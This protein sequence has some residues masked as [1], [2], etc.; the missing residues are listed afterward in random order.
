MRYKTFV[1]SLLILSFTCRPLP[2][3]VVEPD[4]LAPASSS[5]S[6]KSAILPLSMIALGGVVSFSKTGQSVDDNVQ[7]AL[8][9][10]K[11]PITADDYLQYLPAASV[12]GLSLLGVPAKH[13]YIDRTIIMATAYLTTGV[14]TYVGK[15]A[16]GVMRPDGSSNNSFPS[17]HTAVAFTGAEML[18]QE[19]GG[20]YGVGGYAVAGLIGLARIHNNRHWASD[21]IAGAGV[22]ILSARV[23]YWLYPY[24]RRLI[25]GKRTQITALPFY[26]GEAGGLSFSCRF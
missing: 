2:A 23:G 25:R 6:V 8:M 22:G 21:V 16:C 26:T 4:T 7:N 11:R 20:W 5:F 17:G 14:L 24:T 18:R 19:Y 15:Q 10:R 3:Q 1:F 13:D 9:Y 12:Y